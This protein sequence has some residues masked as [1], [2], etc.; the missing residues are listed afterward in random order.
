MTER[1]APIGIVGAGAV[2]QALG[3]C[4]HGCGQPVFGVASRSREHAEAAARFIGA[5]VRAVDVSELPAN[6]SRVLV[7][8][9]DEGI[10][11]V[12]ELLARSGMSGGIAL[13]TCGAAG[14]DALKPLQNA[15]VAC[16]VLHPLQTF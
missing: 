8:V 5:G 2:A 6:V 3:R 13:H 1:P 4:L 7:A 10:Q 14:S 11:P 15:G 9:R 16:G 12:A